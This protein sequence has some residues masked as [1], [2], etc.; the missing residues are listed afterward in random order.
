MKQTKF[1]KKII[2]LTNPF[3]CMLLINFLYVTHLI[4]IIS[5]LNTRI[6]S[7]RDRKMAP[8]SSVCFK[9]LGTLA[10]MLPKSKY[11]TQLSNPCFC[12]HSVKH[13]MWLKVCQITFRCLWITVYTNPVYILVWN[14]HEYRIMANYDVLNINGV[15]RSSNN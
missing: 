12:V 6:L 5:W 14:N 15:N 8:Q 3:G 9:T 11:S 7:G 4:F 1:V 2:F 13:E 10:T